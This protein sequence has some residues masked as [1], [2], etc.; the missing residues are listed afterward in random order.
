MH[1]N[2]RLTSSFSEYRDG[3]YHAGIDIRSFGAVGLPCLA[4]SEGRVA[5]VKVG[6]AGYGK[7]LYLELADG[8]M[9][10]YAHLD[11]FDRAIDSI[12][13]HYRIDR[14]TN[15]CD[16]RLRDARYSYEVGDTVAFSGQT[17]T[18]AP[19]LHFEL[20]DS[21]GRPVNPLVGIYS[22][23]DRTPPII[24]GLMAVPLRSASITEEGPMPAVRYFRASGATRYIMP[25]TLHLDGVFGFSIS[26]WDEQGYGRYRMAP[27]AIELSVDGQTVF[28]V[29]NEV[30]S[31]SQSGEITAEYAVVGEGAAGRFLRL[32][33]V[34]GSTRADRSG[35][36]IVHAG[37][38]EVGTRL[39]NGLH[40]GVLKVTDASGNSSTAL[41]HFAIHSFPV[42]RT[43]RRL[44]AADEIVISAIDPDGGEPSIRAFES[45]DGGARWQP[46]AVDRKGE[47][48]RAPV[49]DHPEAVYR[50]EAIDDEGAVATE[51][52]ASPEISTERDMAF[53][54]IE[55]ETTM[56]G[57]ALRIST[58]ELLAT[59]PSVSTGEGVDLPLYQT[60]PKEYIAFAGGSRSGTGRSV[61]TLSGIDYRGFPVYAA[62]VATIFELPTGSSARFMLSDTVDV[63]IEAP[64][65]RR[66]IPLRIAEVSASNPLPD[67]LNPA[68]G[69]FV[70]DFPAE[71]LSK[72]LKV[73]C[74]VGEKI[75]LFYWK[76]GKGWE[77]A[78]VPARE[79]GYVSIRKPGR[80]AFFRDGIPP[81]IE[82][83]AV[84]RNHGGSGFFKPYYCSIPVFED[85]SGIDPWGAEAR[86][87]GRRVVCEWDEYRKTLIIPVP[88]S[89]PSGHTVIEV[90]VSDLTGN[91]TVG[92]FGFVLE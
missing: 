63:R 85:G 12:A 78:G 7:A 62:K 38:G 90:E 91:R 61:F 54:S 51:W 33:P 46:L 56:E 88:A 13:W 82:H 39:G 25:D 15:W 87:G 24:S 92:E 49:S 59:D 36:G 10:V 57:I 20:R 47:Y 86:L 17:G 27:L 77:C 64:S 1:G 28:S 69:P 22:V 6:A 43:A 84:E 55:P 44:E 72:P 35:S 32:Y 30:F 18:S 16:F 11:Q 68:G 21:A 8:L 73:H 66:G 79:G 75:G 42:I 50:I 40:A 70:M 48:F 67:R 76:E 37:G 19:H 31:Y 23:P 5:R 29:K 26:A 80:Y 74:S 41:F 81:V 4:V 2:R 45:L 14:E 60:G 52:F 89:F 65:L 9:A 53:A 83:V 58:D 3:H 71:Y 34:P